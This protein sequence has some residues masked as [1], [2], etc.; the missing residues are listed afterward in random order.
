MPGEAT[1]SGW[2]A[3][4]HRFGVRCSRCGRTQPPDRQPT[5][6][7]WPY[8]VYCAA[9]LAVQRW[10]AAPPAGLGPPPRLRRTAAAY[11]GPPRYGLL[12]PGW[13][14]PP[15]ARLRTPEPT[16]E[17]S[18]ES[19]FTAALGRRFTAA[20][21]LA[22][23]VFLVGL[24]A[25]ASETWRFALLLRGRTEVLPARL[26]RASDFA[27]GMT[28]LAALVLTAL[29]VPAFAAAMVACYRAAA[30]RAGL[31]PARTAGQVA[32]RFLVPGWNLFGAGQIVVEVVH[33]VF[34][35]VRGI[36]RAAPR[37]V[38]R[39][40]ACCWITWAGAGVLATALAVLAILPAWGASYSNQTA[41]NL[42][43][44]HIVLDLVAAAAALLSAVTLALLRNEWV[45]ERPGRRRKWVVAQAV[46]T[47]RNQTGTARNQTQ[48]QELDP[49]PA[50]SADLRAHAGQHRR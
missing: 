15:I 25:A 10:V 43:E 8:C 42:V 49:E 9:P 21:S 3:D 1:D 11:Q 17:A 41:A 30:R 40:V 14:F 44:V 50:G 12:H 31:Q 24:A 34:R 28:S 29:A 4:A 18:G 16:T 13:G 7:R 33:L 48:T 35:P 36:G 2:G 23:A 20:I 38:R 26:V 45:G 46:S 32:A 19:V 27:V 5:V 37:A 39:V 47:A 6:E 22:L